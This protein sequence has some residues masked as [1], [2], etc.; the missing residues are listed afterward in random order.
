MNEEKLKVFSELEMLVMYDMYINGYDS[1]KKEDIIAYW[2]ER[3][4]K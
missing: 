2:N 1:S 3:L 4:P